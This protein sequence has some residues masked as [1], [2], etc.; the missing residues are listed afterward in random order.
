MGKPD[1]RKSSMVSAANNRFDIDPR[2]RRIHIIR[3]VLQ[4]VGTGAAVLL[5]LRF[6][7]GSLQHAALVCSIILGI[8]VM[9]FV[10]F[11]RTMWGTSLLF[12]DSELLLLRRERVVGRIR[13]DA[14]QKVSS[15]KDN[16]VLHQSLRTARLKIITRD[17]FTEEK[18]QAL[19]DR[20]ETYFG[21]RQLK[22]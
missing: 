20:V 12:N 16:I 2:L 10:I 1:D 15:T 4:L 14:I 6:L 19:R 8:V 18:W 22:R 9:F 13:R 21:T 5:V 11:V 17:G 7:L 3:L